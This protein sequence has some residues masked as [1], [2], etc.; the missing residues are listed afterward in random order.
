VTSFPGGG[1]KWQVSNGL[2]SEFSD[3]TLREVDWSPDGKSLHYR[4][5][6]KIYTVDVS[7]VSGKPEFSPP[8]EMMTIPRDFELISIMADGKRILAT[9]P[10]GQRS[11]PSMDLTINWEHSLR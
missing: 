1:S 6:D 11:S 8:K 10:V 7:I 2:A 3:S 9:R 4:Q 5:A